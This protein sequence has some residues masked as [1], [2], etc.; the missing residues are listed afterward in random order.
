MQEHSLI[1]GRHSALTP[2]GVLRHNSS[3]RMKI[4]DYRPTDMTITSEG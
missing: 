1:S 4:D 2:M 3:I